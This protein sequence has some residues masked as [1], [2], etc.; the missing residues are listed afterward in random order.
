MEFG[1]LGPLEVRLDG[2]VLELGGSKP[3]A[4]L[5]LLA[6]HA[7][8]PVSAERAAVALWGE[9]TSPRAVKTVQVY[10]ARLRKALA[11]PDVLVTTPAGYC[12]KIRPGELDA[13]R[14]ERLVADGRQALAAGRGED[15]AAD[16]RAALKLWRGHPLVELASAPFAPAEI[17]RLEEQHLAALEVRVEADLVAGRHAELVG[18][19]QQLT[20][21]HPWRERLYAQLMLALYRSGRQ[22]DAL[23]A[24]RHA[25]EVLVEQLGIEPGVEL[26]DLHE[27]IL[28]QAPLGGAPVAQLTRPGVRAAPAPP[29][30]TIGRARELAAIGERLQS[31]SVRLLTL[32]GPG[33]VG[34]TRLALEGARSAEGNFA[35]GACFVSFQALQRPGD[36]PAAIVSA[37]GTVVLS[38]ESAEQAV[39]RFLAGKQLLLVL[40]NCE[41]VLAAAP[42]IG[43][44]LRSC[45]GVVVLATSREPLALHA[46]ARHPVP[47]LVLPGDG[48]PQGPAPSDG[49]AVALFAQRARVHD[50]E[51]ELCDGNAAA[52]AE[53]C[54][55]VDGLPLAIE[56]AAARCE[57]LSPA[58][59]AERLATAFG[60]LGTGARDAPAR[61]QTLRATIDWSHELLTEE[62]QDGFARF[63]V[64]RGGAAVKA[65]EAITGA[66]L[67]TLDRLVAKSLLARRRQPDGQTRLMMLET[68]RAYAA[69]RFAAAPDIEAVRERHYAHFLRSALRHGSERA[70]WGTSRK[71]HLSALDADI[72]NLRVAL[73]WAVGQT[74]AESALAM[75]A[76][77]G[78]YWLERDRYAEAIDWIDRALDLPGADD[79]S[80]PR[81][82][83]LCAKS[84]A[85]WP[86][87]RGNE[88]PAVTADAETS[89]RALGDT[90]LLS[91]V[92]QARSSQEG[93]SGR[94]WELAKALAEEALH[95]ARVA[96]DDWWG[97]MAAKNYALVSENAAELRERVFRAASLLSEV[98]NALF[99]ADVLV[100]AAYLALRHGNDSDALE[101]VRRAIPITRGLDHP[102]LW[103]ELRGN[104]AVAALFTDDIVGAREA[105]NEELKLCRELAV[106]P[107]AS[108]GLAGL[109]AVATVDDDLDRA[110]RLHGAASSHRY[111]E[112]NDRID[113]RLHAS[114]FEPAR[115]RHGVE[116][117][118]AVAFEG[119][120]LSFEDALA[121]ALE[122]ASG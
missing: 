112:T 46:E 31:G 19:L 8:Q 15:A 54:R 55:R 30:Q 47:P 38:G 35:D 73:G 68:I 117:W 1:I 6:L 101:F 87:G 51:F 40:D 72:D 105:F 64:F 118:D 25:R 28:A 5:A 29:N 32:T 27:A 115:T 84:W 14:F 75:C 3:R 50:P 22:A 80:V 107:Y 95:W 45:P 10:V 90:A 61:Q 122:E 9:D 34:K 58:E 24:Y 48:S 56:L 44:V 60:A 94:D 119:A 109:A 97:A 81:V 23:E 77:L 65:A 102:Y 36:V 88:Q 18:E 104:H 13:E 106:R 66:S 39:E 108:E 113:A 70:L 42:F 85:L 4:L 110:A 49:D 21:Q 83:A 69:E 103:M 7:N 86:L 116:A 62:E 37:L 98:G 43:S 57:L 11:D 16:L 82:R 91:L 63:A 20:T 12:L 92:L 111:G 33:G 59:V 71:T 114:F 76:A 99:S 17:A 67:D 2:R 74:T 89:A 120:A 41:H 26:H 121:Y 93:T 100:G 78:T 52:V 96:D 79:H 53:I